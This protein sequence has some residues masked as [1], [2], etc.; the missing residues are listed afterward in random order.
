MR[1]AAI[2]TSSALGSVAL[3]ED[4]RVVLER[5]ALAANAH[6]ELLVSMIDAAFAEAGWTPRQ[7]ARWGVGLGPGSFTGVRVSVATAKGIVL[8]TGAELVGVTS[9][10]ALA[11]DL[12]CT[13]LVVSVTGAGRGELFL[14]ARRGEEL[15]LPPSLVRVED[16]AARVD[17]LAANGAVLVAGAAAR[18]ADWSALGSRVTRIDEPPNDWPRARAIA[19]IASTRAAD[20]ADALEPLYVRPPEIT[21]PGK[22]R[23]AG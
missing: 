21:A 18:D 20:D 22:P 9:L 12:G 19:A 5:S 16:V 14:Q 4:G 7:V 17:G 23:R 2:D 1:I 11:H 3:F 8:G 15:V 13:G 6:G 10:D